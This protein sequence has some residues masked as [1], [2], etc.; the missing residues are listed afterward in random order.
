MQPPPGVEAP[1][2]LGENRRNGSQVREIEEGQ[3]PILPGM[4]GYQGLRIQDLQA[5]PRRRL[6]VPRRAGG[7]PSRSSSAR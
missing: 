5:E 1:H 4:Q 7:T 6:V 3:E 2:V